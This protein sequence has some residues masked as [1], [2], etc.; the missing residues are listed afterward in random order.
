MKLEQKYLSLLSVADADSAGDLRVCFELLSLAN[1][2][3][4]ACA[5]RL[6]PFRLSESKFLLLCL[7]RDQPDGAAP[8]ELAE[9]AGVTR[10]TMTG[11]LDGMERDGLLCRQSDIDDRRKIVI[12]LTPP[13]QA[14]AGDLGDAH[15]RWI[16][17]LGAGLSADERGMLTALLGRLRDNLDIEDNKDGLQQ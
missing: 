14:L 17:S 3:D 4:R 8:H 7:L 11:L 13:G 16:A 9:R 1:A 10:A 5:N 6:A 12:R 2:I 15:R